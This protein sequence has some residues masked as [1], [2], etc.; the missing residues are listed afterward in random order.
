MNTPIT[1]MSLTIW[2]RRARRGASVAAATF[3]AA[4]A[5]MTVPGGG[6]VAAGVAGVRVDP[7]ARVG[8]VVFAL[9]VAGLRQLLTIDIYVIG[10]ATE[11]LRNNPR[12]SVC[13][14]NSRRLTCANKLSIVYR[15]SLIEK[16]RKET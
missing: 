4:F 2:R 5:L 16:S 14:P 11:L 8:G 10:P 15:I 12:L 7:R 9:N 1:R 3:F 6:V 13:S